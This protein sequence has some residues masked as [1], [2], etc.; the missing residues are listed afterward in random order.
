MVEFRDRLPCFDEG[1]PLNT[2]LVECECLGEHGEKIALKKGVG[3]KSLNALARALEPERVC[4]GS[5]KAVLYIALGLGCIWY[6][7]WIA[8]MNKFISDVAAIGLIAGGFLYGV[9]FYKYARHDDGKIPYVYQP[10]P[11]QVVHELSPAF[12]C[13]KKYF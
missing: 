5:T 1:K 7:D 4:A 9:A 13:K 8:L 12:S 3:L 2:Y 6:S 10:V 11:Q